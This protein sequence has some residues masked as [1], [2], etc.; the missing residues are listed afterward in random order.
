M[1]T[2]PKR[3]SEYVLQRVIA[4]RLAHAGA[5]PYAS[6]HPEYVVLHGKREGEI[7]YFGLPLRVHR[8]F[9]AKTRS[10]AEQ[11]SKDFAAFA[12]GQDQTDWR[13][14]GIH[15]PT[16][17]TELSALVEDME[18]FNDLINCVFTHLKKDAFKF[19]VLL[20]G[21]HIEFD[22]S[23]QL[24]DIHG[25]FVCSMPEATRDSVRTVLMTKFSRA[26]VPDTPLRSAYGFANYASRPFKL[27]KVIDWPIGALLAA[28][29]LGE[30]GFHYARPAGR[31]RKWRNDN[32]P[33]VDEHAKAK[34][35]AKRE[36]RK[37]T[38]YAGDGWKY[39]D[40]PLFKRMW[41]FDGE[42]VAGTLYRSAHAIPA[43]EPT[44]SPEP[45]SP[46]TYSYP[47]AIGAVIQ[48]SPAGASE[49]GETGDALEILPAAKRNIFELA[50]SSN[51]VAGIATVAPVSVQT[52]SL[53]LLQSPENTMPI[54]VKDIHDAATKLDQSGINPS[55]RA[56]RT[57]LGSGSFSTISKALLTWRP[58]EDPD[59][60]VPAAPADVE[61]YG[62]ELAAY[63]WKV[64]IDH[65]NKDANDRV[66]TALS[67]QLQAEEATKKLVVTA[68]E[69]AVERDKLA[70][71]VTD[72][73]VRLN[74]MIATSN[75]N[76]Q[77]SVAATAKA[78][79]L[80]KTVDQLTAALAGRPAVQAAEAAA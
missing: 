48:T 64:A 50:G 21:I 9:P 55:Q 24:L 70:A 47:S 38:R 61:N 80:Q 20:L 43:R 71:E 3:K 41:R 45:F 68:D 53:Q 58:A 79:T 17:K 28:W 31:F 30:C 44:T 5:N 72:L 67:L 78:E 75:A 27:E 66:Q 6:E 25:H 1:A 60:A 18:A 49:K 69:L 26:H 77:S 39:R 12:A 10:Q 32:K 13:V 37:A 74:K 29:Q 16:R 14:W 40:R 4:E 57:A 8:M 7:K 35:R 54:S 19:E 15:R 63:A 36:N 23:T 11:V 33:S 76:R 22:H 62:K 73:K 46:N 56:V 59:E 42:D 52:V 2:K 65:A 51:M 34:A